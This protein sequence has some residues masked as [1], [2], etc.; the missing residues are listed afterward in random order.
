[1]IHTANEYFLKRNAKILTKIPTEDFFEQKDITEE[2]KEENNTSACSN[3]SST[4]SNGHC[5]EHNLNN[6]KHQIHSNQHD[7]NGFHTTI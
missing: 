2:M 6:S 3:G 5:D 1:M 7:T 4:N